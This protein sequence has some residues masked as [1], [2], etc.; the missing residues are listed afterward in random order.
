MPIVYANMVGGQDELVFDG[1]SA[2]FAAD[3]S[4]IG[5]FAEQRRVVVP[6]RRMPRQLV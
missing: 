6:Y 3:G 2:V 5:E 1:G 4:I